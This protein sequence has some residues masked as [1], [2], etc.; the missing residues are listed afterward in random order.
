MKYEYVIYSNVW[1][2]NG[3]FLIVAVRWCGRKYSYIFGVDKY[4]VLRNFN[5]VII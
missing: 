2:R 4:L 5:L 3:F 1:V